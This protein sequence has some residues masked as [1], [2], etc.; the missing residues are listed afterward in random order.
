[1]KIKQI[2]ICDSKRLALNVNNKMLVVTPRENIQIIIGTNGSGK[3]SLL[4]SLTPLPAINSDYN[5]GGSKTIDIT[6]GKDD[7]TLVSTFS[8][9]QKHSFLKNNEELNPGGTITVQKEL[10]KQEF[11]I[12]Q[13]V[14]NLVTG[15]LKFTD[16]SPNQRRQ[17]FIQ[18]SDVD[19]EYAMGVYKRLKEKSRDCTGALKILKQKIVQL[20]SAKMSREEQDNLRCSITELNSQIANLLRESSSVTTHTEQLE[21]LYQKT[22]DEIENFRSTLTNL[23]TINPTDI[24]P[25]VSYIKAEIASLDN[26][27][28]DLRRQQ[29]EHGSALTEYE[30]RISVIKDSSAVSASELEQEYQDV[31]RRITDLKN[32][33]KLFNGSLD[34]LPYLIDSFNG[35]LSDLRQTLTMIPENKNKEVNSTDIALQKANILNLDKSI[36]RTKITLASAVANIATQDKLLGEHNTKCPNCKHEWVPG[37]EE[38]SY[39]ESIVIRDTMIKKLDYLEAEKIKAQEYIDRAN[40]YLSHYRVYHHITRSLPQFDWFWKNLEEN[41]RIHEFP[42]TALVMVMDLVDEM[43]K[44]SSVPKLLKLKSEI[45][46]KISLVKAVDLNE[47]KNL[48]ESRL[49][50]NGNLHSTGLRIEFVN[51]KKMTVVKLLQEI[52]TSNR[53]VEKSQ[54]LLERT[55]AALNDVVVSYYNDA[56]NK[57]V[58]DLQGESSNKASILNKA[59]N[60]DQLVNELENQISSLEEQDKHYK[61]L[62]ELLSPSDGLI[63][64]GIVGFVNHF[65]SQMNSV[66]SKIWSYGLVIDKTL[67]GE[68]GELDYYFPVTIN[69]GGGKIKDVNEGSD[70]M[71]EIFNLAFKLVAMKYLKLSDYPIYLDEFG[72]AF[73]AVHREAASRAIKVIMDTSLH[74]QLFMSSHYAASY[75]S[76]ANAEI[77]VL[78]SDNIDKT[79]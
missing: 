62:L 1:M 53:I 46:S 61:S 13:E 9:G 27:L 69:E 24:P 73:D 65:I 25:D 17:W 15:K 21:D 7:Y 63:A 41:D 12:T 64:K 36:S 78:C 54:K 60:H 39:K 58:A 20:N 19:Y 29:S 49:L 66:I 74:P 43:Q 31:D 75:G 16:M 35:I 40:E 37:Y 67:I 2:T 51:K 76:F 26:M 71:I 22:L 79:A 6:K 70:G 5:N 11:G 4:D 8:G 68:D 14:H 47:L 3:S 23:K 38:S 42:R 52:E 77:V 32:S 50:L 10:V 18:F 44:L 45:N 56:I 59:Q 28:A 33:T 55:E 72:R 57:L 34:D 48:E 30:K